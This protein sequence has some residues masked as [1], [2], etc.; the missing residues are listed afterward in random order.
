MIEVSSYEQLLTKARGLLPKS[1]FIRRPDGFQLAGRRKSIFISY[2]PFIP[3]LADAGVMDYFWQHTGSECYVP[4][5]GALDSV[6][7]AVALLEQNA[8]IRMPLASVYEA[9]NKLRVTFITGRHLF[10]LMRDLGV[11]AV[12]VMLTKQS[13]ALFDKYISATCEQPCAELAK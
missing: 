5:G 1:F 6:A 3:A 8:V 10:A 13:E 4:P 7:E 11:G 2:R 9:G 12:P